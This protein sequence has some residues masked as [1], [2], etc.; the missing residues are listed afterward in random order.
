VSIVLTGTGADFSTWTGTNCAYGGASAAAGTVYRQDAGTGGG[1]GTV[2][3][4][5]GNANT[6]LPFTCLPAFASATE[7]VSRTLW[8]VQNKGRI[9]MATNAPIWSL[10]V[11]SNSYMELAGRT[12]TTRLLTITNKSYRAGTYTA[13]ELGALVSDTSGGSGS[14]VVLGT[15][16]RGTIIRMR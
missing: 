5:N 12:L 11:S 8:V 1:R 15:S 9:G 3:V 14:V 10:T 13:S 2:I 7:D 6:N 16:G 4:D